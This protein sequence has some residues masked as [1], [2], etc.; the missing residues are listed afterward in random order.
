[1]RRLGVG[2]TYVPGLDR[3]L[4]V[5]ADLV[6]VVEIE[7]QTF[8]R[9]RTDGVISTDEEALRRLADLPGARLLHGVGN[10]VGG[11]Q[12]PDRRHIA[13]FGELAERLATPWVSEHLAFNQVGGKEKGFHT[14]FML[15]PCQ[16]PSGVQYGI[17]SIRAMADALPMPLAVEIGANYLQ[18]RPNELPDGEF[19]CRVVEGSGC[20]LLLD[21]H[22]VLANERNGRCSVDELLDALPLERVWE[23]HLAGGLAHRGYWLDAHSGLPDDDLL[24]L[25]ERVLPRLPSLR[26]VLYEVTPS[27]VPQLDAQAVR[28]LLNRVRSMWPD[29]SRAL[30]PA[31][32]TPR[33][34]D[35]SGGCGEDTPTPQ[36]WEHALGSLA[37]GR[38]TSTPLARQL[39]TDPAIGLLRELITE[40]RGSALTGT[41]RYTLRL[42]LLTLGDAE[43]RELLEAYTRAHPPH[44]FASQEAFA[45]A[46]YLRRTRPAVPWLS[47]VLELDCG[48]TR[49]QLDGKPCTVSLDSD[50]TALLTDLGAGRLPVAPRHG[51]FRVQLVDDGRT[52]VGAP[53][54]HF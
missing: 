19:I 48:L 37:I 49:A 16:T 24:S 21:L 9:S 23:V 7:P 46:D 22:N 47:D 50:P 2:L 1:M 20:G 35:D 40:F 44:L 18:P 39:S 29:T 45:F 25:A 52:A 11:C 51:P 41:L 38:D 33:L 3:I 53:T 43:V 8:W 13:L 28:E 36:E 30:L 4:D 15:P 27:A 17:R 34:A 10:P 54:G 31:L 32:P 5:C 26:A 42:L 14:G 12:L 6:D